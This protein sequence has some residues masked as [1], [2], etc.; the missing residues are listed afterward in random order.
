MQRFVLATALTFA[1]LT[2]TPALAQQ[3]DWTRAQYLAASNCVAHAELEALASDAP[4][5]DALEDALDDHARRVPWPVR[6]EAES[7]A[8]EL[9]RN[10]RRGQISVEQLRADRDRVCAPFVASG[11]VGTSS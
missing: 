8:D 3:Q 4:N 5:V 6:A 9:K 11:L 7:R 2:A 10:A 1:C